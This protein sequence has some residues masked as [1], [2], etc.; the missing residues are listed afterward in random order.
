[1]KNSSTPSKWKFVHEHNRAILSHDIWYTPFLSVRNISLLRRFSH[2]AHTQMPPVF[3]LSPS[4]W[5]DSLESIEYIWYQRM[6]RRKRR[7]VR[8]RR[9]FQSA[10]INTF[11]FKHTN[12]TFYYHYTVWW[13]FWL[14]TALL[15]EIIIVGRRSRHCCRRIFSLSVICVYCVVECKKKK[16]ESKKVHKFRYSLISFSY[17]YVFALVFY[18]SIHSWIDSLYA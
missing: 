1:M 10:W 11:V 12:C 7:K 5:M 3:V 9:G 15:L 14:H 4:L 8:R 2:W 13:P 18:W 6:R 16:Q 17:T